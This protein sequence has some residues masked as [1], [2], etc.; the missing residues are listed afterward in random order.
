MQKSKVVTTCLSS[1][2]IEAFGIGKK[3]LYCNFTG[4]NLY[5]SDIDKDL[6]TEKSNWLEF[7]K[8]IDSLI[9]HDPEDYRKINKEKMNYYMSFPSDLS[10]YNF[11]SNKID[12][13]IER[14]ETLN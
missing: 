9:A 10:T 8:L 4:T 7:S 13:I 6:V 1:A 14:S 12:E 5:H 2:A 11:I 3:I